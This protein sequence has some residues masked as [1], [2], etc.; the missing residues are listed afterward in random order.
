MRLLSEL[1]RR[2]IALLCAAVFVLA[3]EKWG[4]GAPTDQSIAVLPFES[5]SPDDGNASFL[6]LGIQDDLLTRLS[7]LGDFKVISRLA[8]GTGGHIM[9]CAISIS[10]PAGIRLHAYATPAHFEN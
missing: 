5:L 4:T 7:K 1:K 8:R 10:Q 9:C 3:Y 6:A 2:N